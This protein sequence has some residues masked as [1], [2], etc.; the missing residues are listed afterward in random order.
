[1]DA[2]SIRNKTAGAFYFLEVN[3]ISVMSKADYKAK[4]VNVKSSFA[5][6]AL[7]VA[8]NAWGPR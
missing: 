8:C 6:K 3:L 4:Y 2:Y 5:S 7:F 1:M